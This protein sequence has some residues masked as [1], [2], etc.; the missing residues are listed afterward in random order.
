MFLK[1]SIFEI[2]GNYLHIW[3]LRNHKNYAKFSKFT[4]SFW[5]KRCINFLSETK[6]PCR[7]ESSPRIASASWSMICLLVALI[8]AAKMLMS[9]RPVDGSTA[10]CFRASRCKLKRLKIENRKLNF[11]NLDLKLKPTSLLP[12]KNNLEPEVKRN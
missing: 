10:D 1:F 7:C 6:I 9:T 4:R 5:R 11:E 12:V 3:K 8:P 2:T